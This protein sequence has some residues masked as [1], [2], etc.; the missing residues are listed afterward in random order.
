MLSLEGKW[1]CLW[2]SL[3]YVLT[4]FARKPVTLPVWESKLS[5]GLKPQKHILWR[6]FSELHPWMESWGQALIAK[7]QWQLWAVAGDGGEGHPFK[8]GDL[9]RAQF[10]W[11]LLCCSWSRWCSWRGGSGGVFGGMWVMEQQRGA[12]L[13]RWSRHLCWG[14]MSKPQVPLQMFPLLPCWNSVR[15]HMTSEVLLNF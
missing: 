11:P 15:T 3:F 14:Q 4:V 12:E 6:S 8:R 5:S 1:P 9:L 7:K 2:I 10:L 13:C